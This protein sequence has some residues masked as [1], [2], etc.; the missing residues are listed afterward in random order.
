M[1]ESGSDGRGEATGRS[2][3]TG[4][5]AVASHRS[6]HLITKEF[7]VEVVTLPGT[8]LISSLFINYLLNSG[9]SAPVRSILL[10]G[11]GAHVPCHLTL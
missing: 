7:S 10:P 5:H 6:K 11:G 2:S 1:N 4:H 3:S 9:S 8:G